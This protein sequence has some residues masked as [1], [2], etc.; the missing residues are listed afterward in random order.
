[1]AYRRWAEAT[2]WMIRVQRVPSFQGR[3]SVTVSAGKPER[4]RDGDNLLKPILDALVENRVIVD[5]SNVYV[6]EL[7]MRWDEAAIE[8]GHVLV[9]V[10]AI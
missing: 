5:D 4:R 7:V 1:M 10:R 6:R 9:T 8:A 2:A 3:V